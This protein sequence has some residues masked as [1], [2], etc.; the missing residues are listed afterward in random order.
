MSIYV[1]DNA[2]DD[3][4]RKWSLVSVA[5]FPIREEE[6]EEHDPLELFVRHGIG[7]KLDDD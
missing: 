4:G 5:V 1:I 6:E 3:A 2:V 7:K